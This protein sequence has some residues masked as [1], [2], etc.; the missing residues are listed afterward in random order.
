MGCVHLDPMHKH[1]AGAGVS[2]LGGPLF[3]SG[4]LPPCIPR[5][6]AA[7]FPGPRLQTALCICRLSADIHANSGFLCTED[8]SFPSLFLLGLGTMADRGGVW[9]VTAPQWLCSFNSQ[10]QLWVFWF[11]YFRSSLSGSLIFVLFCYR[12]FYILSSISMHLEK[13]RGFCICSG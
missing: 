9:G 1:R 7:V 11:L 3:Q 10:L 4:W 8:L 6:V 2:L 13:E 12:C 5:S